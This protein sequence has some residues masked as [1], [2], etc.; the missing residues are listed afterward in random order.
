MSNSNSSLGRIKPSCLKLSETYI[1]FLTIFPGLS[2][3][4]EKQPRLCFPGCR[5]A[6]GGSDCFKT[7]FLGL[8]TISP[9]FHLKIET[10]SN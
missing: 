5:K 4:I 6:P 2:V 1:F 3:K 8:L 9:I 10:N 7:I